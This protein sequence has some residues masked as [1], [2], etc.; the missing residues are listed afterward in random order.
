MT[1]Y[2]KPS[3]SGIIAIACCG[4]TLTQAPH[5]LQSC[6]SSNSLITSRLTSFQ[7]L[8]VF[9]KYV[10]HGTPL[11]QLLICHEKQLAPLRP[12]SPVKLTGSVAPFPS[13]HPAVDL[14]L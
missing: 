14:P 3:A 6:F 5:P 8:P 13:P 7:P 12:R 2:M 1:G 4:Q 10:G 9:C 11:Y